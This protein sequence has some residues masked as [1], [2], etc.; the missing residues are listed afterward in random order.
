MKKNTFNDIVKPII[1][2]A[3][4]CLVVAAAL[5]YTNLLTAP[6]IDAAEKEAAEQARAE[7][8]SEADSFSK[9]D[10]K[11]LPAEIT[12][13][14]KADNGTG[15]VFIVSTKGYGGLIKLI[16]GIKSDGSIEKTKTLTHSETSGIGSRVVE[17]DSGYSKEYIG[18]TSDN[19]NDVDALSGAT[20][21]STAYKKAI[22]AAFKAYDKVKGAE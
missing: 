17:N 10:I 14:Y 19:F 16:C 11:G 5:A 20:I 21:S 15:Y 3:G 12:E 2:L 7:V 9:V 1:V 6:V 8:L 18:K 13:A 22:T 4:I